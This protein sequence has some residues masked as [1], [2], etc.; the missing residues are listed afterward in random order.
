MQQIN[1]SR[2]LCHCAHKATTLQER[3]VDEPAVGSSNGEH[4]HAPEPGKE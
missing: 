2:E 1:P 3:A 4:Y